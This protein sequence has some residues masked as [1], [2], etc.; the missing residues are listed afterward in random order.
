MGRYT[1]MKHT[2]VNLYEE[3]VEILRNNGIPVS[4]A[5]RELTHYLCQNGLIGVLKSVGQNDL[6]EQFNVKIAQLERLKDQKRDLDSKIR[7]CEEQLEFIMK[8]QAEIKSEEGYQDRINRICEIGR[9]IDNIIFSYE[10]DIERIRS[11]N[12]P[13]IEEMEGINP[14][15]SLEEHI[16]MKKKLSRSNSIL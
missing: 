12:I 13:E 2:S 3:D 10:Y 1:P 15:W 5:L 6:I 8:C 9:I 16:E 4:D 11:D 14:G 7:E